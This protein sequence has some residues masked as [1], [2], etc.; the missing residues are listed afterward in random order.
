[1]ALIHRIKILLSLVQELDFV[2][3]NALL[4][5]LLFI[6]CKELV[7]RDEYYE[8]I[9]I[10]GMPYSFQVAA[11]KQYLISKKY[12]EHSPDWVALPGNKRLATELDF[13]EK[14]AIQELKNK[15]K[16]E[17]DQ[18]LVRHIAKNY[19]YYTNLTSLNDV[20][21]PEFYTI[22]YEG[23]SLEA[24]V[25]I[26]I[27]KKVRALV[28]VRRNSL[29]KKYGFSKSVLSSVLPQVGIEYM[30][31]PEL[32]IA[33][34]KRQHLEND[35]DYEILFKEYE[36]TT[37]EHNKDKLDLLHKILEEKK[38]IAITCFEANPFHCHRSRVARALKNRKGFSYKIGHLGI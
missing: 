5:N 17:G 25:N 27:G 26:L 16:N 24:Y 10:D 13:F 11:D 28:D 8:F 15:W 23:I 18:E 34:D 12:I 4:Q 33:S 22:G 31:I 21:Q 37:L 1:M 20:D 2:I 32:G 3:P 36:T 29:S 9:P 35:S 19:P 38:R 6:Y 7:K 14:I 30:H